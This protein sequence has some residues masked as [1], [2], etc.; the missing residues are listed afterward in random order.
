MH[1]AGFDHPDLYSKHVLVSSLDGR[2]SFLDWQRSHV[3]RFVDWKSRWR[4]L[5]ALDATLAEELAT[6]RERL[7][8]LCAYLRSTLAIR[9]PRF[10]LVRSIRRIET[11][12]Q[13]LKRRRR[14]RELGQLPLAVGTQN[15]IW[16]D[17]EA[18]CVTREFQDTLNGQYPGWLKLAGNPRTSGNRAAPIGF[19]PGYSP[20][21]ARSP[22]GE[23]AV[24]VV[25][26]MDSSSALAV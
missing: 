3:R 26:L 24:P 16:V 15:L 19:Y 18:L 6:P 9:V 21:C 2:I 14:I 7:A 23:S 25:V 22:M 5:A 13:R 4:D 8:C 11:Q 17:G 12:S 20:R 10:F 1:D